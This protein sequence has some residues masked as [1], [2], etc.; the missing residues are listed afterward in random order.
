MNNDEL[1]SY[2]Y[3][4]HTYGENTWWPLQVVMVT[5]GTPIL[6]VACCHKDNRKC[7]GFLVEFLYLTNEGGDSSIVFIS[8]LISAQHLKRI[9][10]TELKETQ[11]RL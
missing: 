5:Y 6:A 11:F 1:M 10:H 7:L 9:Y 8:I 3:C 2:C 4:L